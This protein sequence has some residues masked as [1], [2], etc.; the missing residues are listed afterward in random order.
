MKLQLLKNKLIGATFAL[1]LI[2]SSGVVFNSTAQAQG[3]YH[4]PYY[5]PHPIYRP[6]PSPYYAPPNRYAYNR[7]EEE[8]GYRDGLDRGQEDART[9]RSFD[10]NNSSHYRNGNNEYREGFRRGYS[11]GYR[12]NS[13][14]RRY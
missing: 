8:K 7:Y 2:L 14:Y 13:S 5:P 4:R 10:P 11:V 1:G 12:Q 9:H 6:V 3:W